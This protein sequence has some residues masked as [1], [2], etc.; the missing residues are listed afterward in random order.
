M[1]RLILEARKLRHLHNSLSDNLG[2]LRLELVASNAAQ[3]RKQAK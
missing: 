1:G 3:A 2:A